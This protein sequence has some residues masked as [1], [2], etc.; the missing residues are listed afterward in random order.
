[1]MK[2]R[3]NEKTNLYEEM[4]KRKEFLKKIINERK[5]ELEGTLQGIV[6]VNCNKRTGQVQFYFKESLSDKKWKYIKKSEE[7]LAGEILQKK[8]N[9]RV[10]KEAERELA[11]IE[12]FLKKHECDRIAGEF[13]SMPDKVKEMVNPVEMDDVSYA[14]KWQSIEYVHKPFREDDKT[15]YYTNKHERV[16]SKSEINIANMLM[17]AGVPYHYEFPVKGRNGVVYHPDFATLNV[18]TREVFYWEHLGR[19]DDREY[20]NDNM[21]KYISYKKIGLVPGDNLILTFESSKYP[22]YPT[23]IEQ[24]INRILL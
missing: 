7:R 24:I 6:R 1:M 10:V 20:I 22:L 2:N 19:V 14:D 5:K 12:K 21:E 13:A 16:R 8:Y 15:E 9:Q 17:A 23:D 4:N 11:S 18:R 3:K